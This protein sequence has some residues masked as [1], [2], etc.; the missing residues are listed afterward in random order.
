MHTAASVR[1]TLWA[2]IVGLLL[3]VSA[4]CGL[5]DTFDRRAMLNDIAHQVIVPTY[6]A[7]TKQAQHLQTRLEALDKDPSAETLRAAR[8]A[9][10]Q[11][12]QTWRETE[13]FELGPVRRLRL[14]SKINFWPTRPRTI[15]KA[16]SS[17]STYDRSYIQR[18]SVA[19]KGLPAIEHI[20]FGDNLLGSGKNQRQ[21]RAYLKALAQDLTIHA[22]TLQNAW[23]AQGDNYAAVWGQGQTD[24]EMEMPGETINML[25]NRVIFMVENLRHEKLGKPLGKKS[26]GKVQPQMV[27]APQS[28]T[29]KALALS[30]LKGLDQLYRGGTDSTQGVGLQ[31]YVASKDKAL[32]EQIG[33]QIQA[34]T[35]AVEQIP[36]PLQEAV[37][38]HPAAVEQAYQTTGT[39]LR[40]IKVD[41]AGQLGV[42]L[43]FN[44]NDGD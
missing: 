8:Q 16:V 29:S 40:L 11:A 44:D 41:M 24:D 10:Q 31:S 26:G 30:S 15:E 2:G 27:E 33:Q 7:F 28:Q 18:L 4:G 12:S 14:N 3:T 21:R 25:A 22:E 6:S 1:T 32:A 20:L 9:W 38:E 19:A 39:L 17:A 5:F 13:A 43:L 42:T 35:A 34:T 36:A 37:K 23:A